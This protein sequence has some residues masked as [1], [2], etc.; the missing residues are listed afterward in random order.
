MTQL[1]PVFVDLDGTLVREDTTVV[2]L[3]NLLKK[4]P[5]K[6]F[7]LSLS[8]LTGG[9]SRLKYE[10]SKSLY[11]NF[12]ELT[13]NQEILD[14]IKELKNKGHDLYLASGTVF[15]IAEMVSDELGLFKKVIATTREV[16]MVSANKKKAIKEI[17]KT[18]MYLGNSRADLKVW[19]EASEIVIVSKSKWLLNKVKAMN[20]PYKLFAI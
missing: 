13:I 19:D 17:S 9:R 10:I 11:I 7:P 20:I 3:L 15:E 14:Y 16:N 18:Y 6:I 12:N 4:K 2:A 5:Y 8:L 1:M